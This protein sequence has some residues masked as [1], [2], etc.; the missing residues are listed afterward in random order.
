M[1]IQ[2]LCKKM[3]Q[4]RKFNPDQL[5][6]TAVSYFKRFYVCKSVMEYAPGII[7]CDHPGVQIA[8]H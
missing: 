6:A 7:T 3:Y 2:D 8:R 4:L 5:Q 1:L